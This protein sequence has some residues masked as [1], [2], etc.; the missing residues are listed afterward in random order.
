MVLLDGDTL[1]ATTN[2]P[3]YVA[4]IPLLTSFAY[5]FSSQKRSI[6][7][8][9]QASN[10]AAIS[11]PA[12]S[13]STQNG[14]FV[15]L[16]LFRSS[17]SASL[18]HAID[19]RS[20]EPVV[21][22]VFADCDSHKMDVRK[23][24]LL[25]TVDGN[26]TF[27]VSYVSSW[28]IN[29]D[30]P[31]GTWPHCIIMEK[32]EVTLRE[33]VL[34]ADM[35][36]Q[37]KDFACLS[38]LR[39]VFQAIQSN[40]V[41]TD[42]RTRNFVR[43]GDAWKFCTIDTLREPGEPWGRRVF[44]AT[45][46]P[47]YCQSCGSIPSC[48]SIDEALPIISWFVAVTVFEIQMSSAAF[49]DRNENFLYTAVQNVTSADLQQLVDKT[50]PQSAAR[51]ILSALLVLEPTMRKRID[52][53]LLNLLG[54]RGLNID[55][56]NVFSRANCWRNGS[57]T[58]F[59][60]YVSDAAVHVTRKASEDNLAPMRLAHV[61]QLV[62][63]CGV[64]SADVFVCVDS[65]VVHNGDG[66]IHIFSKQGESCGFVPPPELGD[67]SLAEWV[68]PNVD[69][70]YS[71]EEA[72][73]R[74]GQRKKSDGGK[75]QSAESSSNALD[76]DDSVLEQLAPPAGWQNMTQAEIA[77]EMLRAVDFSS[78]P[79]SARQ[80][81]DRFVKLM[82]RKSPFF[83]GGELDGD[84]IP[85]YSSPKQRRS[86]HL[87]TLTDTSTTDEARR[88]KWKKYWDLLRTELGASQDQ[89][90]LPTDFLLRL[91][92]LG[93]DSDDV[94]ESISSL[95]GGDEW[96][97]SLD[98]SSA[99]RYSPT[100]LLSFSHRH[101]S[102]RPARHEVAIVHDNSLTLL[103]RIDRLDAEELLRRDP[104]MELLV[105]RELAD[106]GR[107]AAKRKEEEKAKSQKSRR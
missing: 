44:A 70:L 10:S 16:N 102:R 35:T 65:N 17:V 90:A 107:R 97:G 2:I 50:P 79:A 63:C 94:N 23:R 78:Q 53:P 85:L 71:R 48:P 58:A 54:V 32:G 1:W 75:Q 103:D 22:K 68:W 72:L 104:G 87:S 31:P 67:E 57:M 64:A 49:F 26:N 92:T 51:T 12:A 4:V 25:G 89:H 18:Y 86:R 38:V 105:E 73:Q 40:L 39:I 20:S 66:A 99:G 27:F 81:V 82:L 93:H 95:F 77:N 42:L 11:S 46:P 62:T 28:D 36:Q 24:N 43:V 21:A 9:V 98:D 59:P 47:E 41:P 13:S 14:S 15:I 3:G 74:P 6:T 84:P 56:R 100:A 88:R 52:Q 8:D 83:R 80:C 76:I 45:C 34:E 61:S 7:A 37:E 91:P 29:E 19:R 60:S 106:A 96:V 33:R 69:D 30:L 5:F 101:A 55:F